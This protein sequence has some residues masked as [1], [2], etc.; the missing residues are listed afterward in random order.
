RLRDRTFA[1][2]WSGPVLVS[3]DSTGNLFTGPL[4]RWRGQHSHR[5]RSRLNP[6]RILSVAPR[7]GGQH[8]RP[9]RGGFCRQRP[10]EIVFLIGSLPGSARASRAG[11]RV[12]AVT[13][14][15]TIG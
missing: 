9:R 5:I 11:D 7:S 6:D 2:D 12:P 14:F 8:D 1:D 4:V 13:N 15:N 3:G 10:A